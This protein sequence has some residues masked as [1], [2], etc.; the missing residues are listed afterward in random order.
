[1]AGTGAGGILAEEAAFLNPA[2][3]VF[4]NNSTVYVQQD[5]QKLKENSIDLPKHKSLGF[6]VADGN[7]SLSGSLSY[8]NQKEDIYI[9]KR[10]GFSM[11]AP[12]ADKSAFGISLRKSTDENTRELTSKKYYQTVLGVTHVLD[13]K[14]TLGIIAYD[15]FKSKGQET[16]AIVGIQYVL[17]AYI[18]A[19]FDLGADY[20]SSE[21][22]KTILLRGALQIKVLDDFYMRFGVFN[23]KLRSEKG[24]GYGL[25]WVQP[26]LSFE[27]SLKDTKRAKD[28]GLGL[29][30]RSAK[31]TSLAASMRF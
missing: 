27:F 29:T 4:F 13:E 12:L 24:N 30:E 25:A 9:R 15:P 28:E 17:M 18:S 6:V 14:L 21:I 23:D 22:S 3:L 1:M 20:Y 19:A 7:P 11:S 31:E 2:S 10:W 26:K 8:I 5:T 16:K